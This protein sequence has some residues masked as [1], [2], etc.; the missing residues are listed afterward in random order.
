MIM[1]KFLLFEHDKGK[2]A[3]E[4]FYVFNGKSIDSLHKAIVCEVKKDIYLIPEYSSCCVY[5]SLGIPE[6]HKTFIEY[7]ILGFIY[8]SY[9]KTII[10][11]YVIREIIDEQY[12]KHKF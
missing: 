2:N 10:K 3:L 4:L 9:H 5:V 1:K 7:E 8:P 6:S 11:S 12:Y